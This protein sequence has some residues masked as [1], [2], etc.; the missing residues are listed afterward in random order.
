MD[1]TSVTPAF[2]LYNS[3]WPILSWPDPLPPAKFVFEEEGRTGIAVDS[4]VCAGVIV[5]GGR[6]RRS[7]LS[8]GVRVHSFAE[9]DSSVLLHGVDVGRG[10][11]VRNAILDKNV[12]IAEGAQIGVDPEADR[13]RFVVSDGGIVVIGKG[14]KVEAS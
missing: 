11:I 13:E 7:I 1:L 4:L 9:I 12:Q 2:S 14:E 10:A 3:H 8:P 6:V 5:S